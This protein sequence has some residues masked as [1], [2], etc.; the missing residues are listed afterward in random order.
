MSSGKQID[1]D[2]LWCGSLLKLDFRTRVV[3][4]KTGCWDDVVQFTLEGTYGTKSTPIWKMVLV[5]VKK[6]INLELFL[7]TLS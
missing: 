1:S 3:L 7:S 5:F 4:E 6:M 2:G